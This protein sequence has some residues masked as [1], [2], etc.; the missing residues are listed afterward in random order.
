MHGFGG[1]CEQEENRRHQRYKRTPAQR[2][3]TEI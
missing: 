2:H 3:L 1:S